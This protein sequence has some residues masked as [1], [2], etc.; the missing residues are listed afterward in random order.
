MKIML[1]IPC[2]YNDLIHYSKSLFDSVSNFKKEFDNVLIFLVVQGGKDKADIQNI[3][4]KLY[5]I[6]VS[7]VLECVDWR[8]VSRA[9]NLGV[10]YARKYN[11]THMVF[12]D[13]S[14]YYP[15]D[16]CRYFKSNVCLDKSVKVKANFTDHIPLNTKQTYFES[17]RF[18]PIYEC[19]V[20]CWMFYVKDITYLFDEGI[21]PGDT[22]VY[23]SGEDVKF[24]FDNFSMLY[25]STYIQP[26]QLCVCHPPRDSSFDK[27]LTYAKG[28]GFLFRYLIN[29]YPMR[30]RVW[31][32]LILFFGNAIYRVLLCKKNS[33]LILKERMKGLLL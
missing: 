14:L 1:V 13:I 31:I 22:T 27:H 6:N 19:Y 15:E 4:D 24:L 32:D 12:H 3:I 7:I 25:Q 17:I 26:K 10:N 23:K 9:R 11:Y 16:T 21:G 8:N 20:W 29:R 18:N 2:L 28:Q 5:D 33:L 30:L